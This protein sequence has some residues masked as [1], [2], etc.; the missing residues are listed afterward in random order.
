MIDDDIGEYCCIL[1]GNL[2]HN[3]TIQDRKG[4]SAIMQ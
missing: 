4:Y 2:V 1:C 3:S